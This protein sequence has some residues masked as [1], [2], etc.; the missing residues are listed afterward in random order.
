MIDG[1]LIVDSGTGNVTWT[2]VTDA[3]DYVYNIEG[4]LAPQPTS[5]TYFNAKTFIDDAITAGNIVKAPDDKYTVVVMARNESA[6]Y[7]AKSTVEFTYN[8]SAVPTP[9]NTLD[10]TFSA[11]TGK[12]TWSAYPGADTYWCNV[13]G[14]STPADSNSADFAYLIDKMYTDDPTTLKSSYEIGVDAYDSVAGKRVARWA[15]TYTYTPKK[16]SPGSDA[17]KLPSMPVTFNAST[18]KAS[19]SA[20]PGA[21]QYW[22]GVNGGYHPLDSNSVDFAAELDKLYSSKVISQKSSYTVSV[23]AYDSNGPL[24][25]WS[26]A[27]NYTP[28]LVIISAM[29]DISGAAKL[30]VKFKASSGKASWKAYAGAKVFFACVDEWMIAVDSPTNFKTVIDG[31]Y[32]SGKLKKRS[33][34]QIAILAYADGTEKLLAAWTTTFKFKPAPTLKRATIA[35]IVEQTYTGKKVKPKLYITIGTTALKKGKHYKVSF[36]NNKKIGKATVT[37]KGKGK[38][39]GKVKKTFKIVPAA[40]KLKVASIGVKNATVQW[41]HV[42]KGTNGVVVKYGTDRSMKGAKTKTIKG[43]ATKQL[44]LN[45]LPRDKTIFV[46]ISTYKVVKG[47]KYTSPWNAIWFAVI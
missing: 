30:P 42:T 43:T 3:Y 37:I 16:L 11:S 34:Y 23:R 5:D 47:K 21:T 14:K 41:K 2:P 35:K 26:A 9:V 46:W 19:W 32:L 29:P 18:G 1:G 15:A 27:F 17:S 6:K 10:V 20:Y 38:V 39:K 24:A 44:K 22:Y 12:A 40:P 33:S 31:M 8:S 36:K 45:S 4:G 25:E 28:K 13:D 7:I